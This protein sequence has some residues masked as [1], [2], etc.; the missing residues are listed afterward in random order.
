MHPH[1]SS[2]RFVLLVAVLGLASLSALAQSNSDSEW[3]HF[4]LNFSVGLNI[5]A[6]FN[7][8]GASTS[9]AQ[10]GPAAGGGLGRSYDD[11]YVR[12]DSSGN[13]GGMTWNWGYQNASQVSGNG[14]LLM[15]ASSTAVVASQYGSDGADP[16]L[17]FEL[18]Y[19]RDLGHHDWGRWGIKF[20]FGYTDVDIH[21]SRT[22]A[23]SSTLI[24]DAYPLGGITPPLAPYAG[25]F[26]G[27]GPVIGDTPT[28]TISVGPGGPVVTGSRRLDAALY[29]LR[30]GP[31]IELP[32][33]GRLTWQVG[34]GLALGIVDSTFTFADTTTTTAGAVQASG[35]N[36]RSSGLVGAYAE[37]GLVYRVSRPISVFAGAQ[38]QYLGDFAQSA[39]GRT[40]QLDLS[41][42]VFFLA[43]VQ[44]HF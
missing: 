9:A 38:F 12:V 18:N 23:T 22:L 40:A 19:E 32:L 10:T 8:I 16:N 30:L 34:G 29:D 11:G 14:T 43:G 25:T 36:S 1:V 31:F 21:D 17:G 3:N 13:Q 24:T 26:N 35:S 6:K 28:R 2:L 42:S 15:H 37:A 27:P 41:Q 44:W 4:G 20:A 7:S 5:D 39:A 33:W